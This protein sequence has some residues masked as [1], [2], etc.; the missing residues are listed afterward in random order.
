MSCDL[1]WEMGTQFA[2]FVPKMTPSDNNPYEPP[3]EQNKIASR[4]HRMFWIG[5]ALL[6]LGQLI[7]SLDPSFATDAAMWTG[8]ITCYVG[9]AVMFVSG[10]RWVRQDATR[11]SQTVADDS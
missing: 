6:I 5:V 7:M 1:V 4:R 2:D 10:L 8:F 11:R 3:K 9:L